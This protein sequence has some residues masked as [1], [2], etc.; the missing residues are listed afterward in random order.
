MAAL[1]PHLDERALSPQRA[2]AAVLAVAIVLR[3]AYFVAVATSNSDGFFTHDSHGYWLLGGNVMEHG[4]FSLESKPPY[5]PDHSRTPLYPLVLGGLAAIGLSPGAI[6]V[7][8]LVAS[9]LTCVLTM[10]LARRLVPDEPTGLWAGVIVA[11]DVP[12]I[13]LA[14]T[15]LTETLFTCLVVAALLVLVRERCRWRDAALAGALGGAAVL[16]RP[17][18]IG[19]PAAGAV[20]LAAR[21]W[22]AH[23]LRART[24][25]RLAGPPA[26]HL[27][28][29]GVVVFPWVLRNQLTFGE[30]FISTIAMTNLIDYRAAGVESVVE[31]VSL[32]TA[33]A[34][35]DARVLDSTT[36]DPEADPI[37]FKRHQ[38][39]VAMD[40]IAAH[41][42][43]YTRNHVRSVIMMLFAPLRSGIDVQLGLADQGT[44]LVD[45]GAA[46]A[47][48]APAGRGPLARLRATTSTPGLVLVAVQIATTL[49]VTAL[50]LLGLWRLAA[51]RR[52]HALAVLVGVFAYFCLLSGG[53]EAYARFRLPIVPVMAVLADAGVHRVRRA[54]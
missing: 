52:A 18:A 26:L 4:A 9:A 31:K 27:A 22:V 25:I 11:L 2:E 49:A 7:V 12:S 16:C 33:R 32:D 15:L 44:S 47:G 5:E 36:I 1:W 6:V 28:L 46:L 14:N 17:I 19:L 39:D 13:A 10:R 54:R 20:Y 53:P 38:A 41:P 35:L 23:G 42:L 45:W 29:A 37:A 3:V 24:W 34:R 51:T 21:G 43:V 48:G 30:T 50:A 8:Q 40:A